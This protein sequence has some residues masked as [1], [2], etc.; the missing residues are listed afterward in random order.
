MDRRFAELIDSLEPK[1][2]AL[3]TMPPIKYGAL[4]R[5][6]P[7]RG[8]YLFS[9][10]GEHLYVGR[11]NRLRERLRGHCIPSSTHFTATFA[12]R[13]ARKMT[14]KMQASYT[15]SGSRAD[16]L[17]DVTFASAFEAAK[18]R[19][20]SMDLRFVEESDPTRQALLEIYT[21]TVL[22]TPYNDFDNH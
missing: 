2:Q 3:V 19:I 11:T 10:A 5:D 18:R 13:M 14:G 4:P 12:F 7:A 22:R 1:Y 15:K 20:A 21:A 6:L 17:K 16:L 8:I 9:E